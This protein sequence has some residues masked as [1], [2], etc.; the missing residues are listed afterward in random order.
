MKEWISQLRERAEVKTFIDR[1]PEDKP[2]EEESENPSEQ[3][4]PEE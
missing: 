3:T 1:I 2:S 4:S